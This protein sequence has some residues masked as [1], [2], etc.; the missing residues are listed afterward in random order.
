MFQIKKKTFPVCCRLDYHCTS[1]TVYAFR[2]QWSLDFI[3]LKGLY[4]INVKSRRWVWCNIKNHITIWDFHQNMYVWTRYYPNTNTLA[5][6]T[7]SFFNQSN[8]HQFPLFSTSQS[9]EISHMTV[10]PFHVKRYAYYNKPYAWLNGIHIFLS[11]PKQND[12]I[13][14]FGNF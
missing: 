3:F 7:C 13:K 14:E 10:T 1:E 11:F 6:M 5:Y 9:V 12:V 4:K 8:I 2:S